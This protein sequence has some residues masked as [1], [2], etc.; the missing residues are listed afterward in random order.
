MNTDQKITNDRMF[1]ALIAAMLTNRPDLRTL[2][3]EK[4]KAAIGN[5]NLDTAL[6]AWVNNGCQ[7]QMAPLTFDLDADPFL[8]DGESIV[9][10]EK[11]GK[12]V[13]DLGKVVT[14]LTEAQKTAKGQ[15]GEAWLAEMQKLSGFNATFIDCLY[16][17][18]DHPVVA[19]FLTPLRGQALFATKTVLRG[20]DIPRYVRCL[21]FDGERWRRDGSVL[22]FD[23]YSYDPALRPASKPSAL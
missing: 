23:W 6:A 9:E 18:Q 15:G 2:E 11:G 13:F 5:P 10:N 22:R 21:G 1:E 14:H 4:V 12:F 7:L 17:N 16:I 20:S 3:F 8:Y 19:A